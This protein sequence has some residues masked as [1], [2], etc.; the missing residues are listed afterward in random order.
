MEALNFFN[1]I[2]LFKT[3]LLLDTIVAKVY[4]GIA[5]FIDALSELFYSFT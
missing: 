4:E 3:A 1:P 2:D 5:Y